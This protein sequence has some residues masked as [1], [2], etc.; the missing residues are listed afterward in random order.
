MKKIEVVL[1][2]TDK[3]NLRC[4]YCYNSEKGYN[5]NCVSPDHFEK[6]LTLLLTDYNLIHVIFHGG[7]PTSLGLD[8]FKNAMDVE[9]KVNLRSG[10]V[11]ENSIQTNGTLINDRW[12]DFF[13]KYGF[14]VGVSFDG[15]DNEKYRGQTE[16]VLKAMEKMKKKGLDFSCLAVVADDDYDLFE[17]YRFFAEKKIAFDFSKVFCEGAAKALPETQAAVYADKLVSL[18]D[19][20]IKDVDGVSIRTFAA[21]IN[22]A[23]G[24]KFR[25]CSNCS[26]HGKYISMDPDGTLFNC[27]RESMRAY[28]F[29]NVS[30]FE[31]AKDVFKTDG[32]VSLI[33]GSIER[34]NECKKS[35][36]FFSL[37][38]GGCADLS[39]SEG[40]LFSPPKAACTVFK[41][42]YAHVAATINEILKNKVPLNEL[43]PA[44]RFVL[45]KNYARM[46]GNLSSQISETYI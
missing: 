39:I 46:G 40:S 11:I 29:G 19:Y 27:G 5:N 7:E 43:N 15:A 25:I 6:L 44:V 13:K 14:K 23:M 24:G 36:E 16:N 12:I 28:P 21:Y 10:V 38:Q 45:A 17:N 33:K 32:A 8:F 41:I 3:C 20:W 34:R 31:T 1:K 37:C 18:F 42:V 4:R 35:C 2:V 26:C 30:D 9:R 22:M